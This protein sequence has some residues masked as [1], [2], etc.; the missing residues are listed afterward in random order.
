MEGKIIA[1]KGFAQADGPSEAI[2]QQANMRP[3]F[4]YYLA[5]HGETVS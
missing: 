5:L 2:R 1:K 3:F 4:S